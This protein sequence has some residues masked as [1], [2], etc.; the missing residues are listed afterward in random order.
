MSFAGAPRS[1]AKVQLPPETVQPV[2]FCGH[3]AIGLPWSSQVMVAGLLVGV[4]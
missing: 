3:V 4:I 2:L 1:H